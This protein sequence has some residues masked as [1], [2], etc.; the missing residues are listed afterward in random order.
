M[1]WRGLIRIEGD[2][3]LLGIESLSTHMDWGRTEHARKGRFGVELSSISPPKAPS[4]CGRKETPPIREDV[5]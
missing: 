1:D 3:D 5:R 4:I 2:F